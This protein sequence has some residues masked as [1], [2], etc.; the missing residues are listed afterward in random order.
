[1]L[2]E[3]KLDLSQ[4][5]TADHKK[6]LED[7]PWMYEPYLKYIEE[8]FAEQFREYAN[9][10]NDG[11]RPDHNAFVAEHPALDV[12]DLISY[13]KSIEIEEYENL[14]RAGQNPDHK[15]YLESH[16]SLTEDDLNTSD[17]CFALLR[18]GPKK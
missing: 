10:F 4:R 9:A 2:L 17:F 15:T 3:Y 18:G 14:L 11:Q 13:D 7:N 12:Y 6:F 1:M 8:H 5:G 16:P